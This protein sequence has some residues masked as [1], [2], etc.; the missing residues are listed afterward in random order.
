[1]NGEGRLLLQPSKF[2]RQTSKSAAKK[3][4]ETDWG[5]L[6]VLSEFLS[7]RVSYLMDAS[8]NFIAG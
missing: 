2:L 7:V 6:L 1:M 4:S 5:G 8:I 3:T